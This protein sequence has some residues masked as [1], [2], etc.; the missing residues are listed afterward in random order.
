MFRELSSTAE[1]YRLSEAFAASMY[2]ARCFCRLNSGDKFKDLEVASFP[3]ANPT[4]R[5]VSLRAA[6]QPVG[7]FVVNKQF[8]GWID[9]QL[10]LQNPLQRGRVAGNVRR[11]HDVLIA[12][13]KF[14]RTHAIEEVASMSRH[15]QSAH[16]FSGFARICLQLRLLHD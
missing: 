12:R 15:V 2:A 8:R 11:P 7:F 3:A 10:P 5:P 13:R 4:S 1:R 9:R 6:N 16:A 14:S